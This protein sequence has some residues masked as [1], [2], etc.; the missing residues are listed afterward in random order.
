[1]CQSFVYNLRGELVASI[2]QE[3]LIRLKQ[4]R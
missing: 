3:G 2:A 1:L 4:P